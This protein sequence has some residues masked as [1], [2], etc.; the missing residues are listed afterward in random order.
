MGI[1]ITNGFGFTVFEVMLFLKNA[2]YIKKAKCANLS[3]EKRKTCSTVVAQALRFT[4][5]VLN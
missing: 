5:K 1:I 3:S 4:S 2:R